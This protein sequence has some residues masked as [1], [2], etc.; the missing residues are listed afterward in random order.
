MLYWETAFELTGQPW[1]PCIQPMRLKFELANRDSAGG[2]TVLS[3]NQI[4][5]N[6]KGSEVG[7]R[8][9]LEKTVNI[10]ENWFTIQRPIKNIKYKTLCVSNLLIWGWKWIDR[11][12]QITLRWLSPGTIIV[13]SYW[14]K[15]AVPH[16]I[17]PKILELSISRGPSN[18]SIV[19]IFVSWEEKHY[20]HYEDSLK[21]LVF[22]QREKVT[23]VIFHG[24]QLESLKKI[25]YINQSF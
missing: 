25:V 5:V 6:R 4:L 23:G 9:S 13:V 17:K 11:V 12:W 21:G 18:S 16:H 7:Q 22:I 19:F 20:S 1:Q 3:W 24:V 2:K 10:H 15:Y 14:A 8:F